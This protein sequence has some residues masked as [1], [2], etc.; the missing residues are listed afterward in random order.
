[1]KAIYIFFFFFFL[2]YCMLLACYSSQCLRSLWRKIPTSSAV[3]L[4]GLT[5]AGFPSLN[6]RSSLALSTWLLH[7]FRRTRIH[8]FMFN[9]LHRFFTPLFLILSNNEIPLNGFSSVVLKI[10]Q[11]QLRYNNRPQSRLIYFHFGFYGHEWISP[12]HI[13][14]I[15]RY[16]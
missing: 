8:L 4:W 11:F 13:S 12:D 7:S 3:C 5:A 15:S 16:F 1:M 9:R 6:S 10:F 14:K 2:F